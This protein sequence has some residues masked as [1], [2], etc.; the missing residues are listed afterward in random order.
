MMTDTEIRNNGSSKNRMKG[1]AIHELPYMYQLKR[2]MDN[3][4]CKKTFSKS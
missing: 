2:F 4:R 1:R 3:L